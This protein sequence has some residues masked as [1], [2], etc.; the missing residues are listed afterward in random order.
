MAREIKSVKD[1]LEALDDS[2]A[3]ISGPRAKLIVDVRDFFAK[4]HANDPAPEPPAAEPVAD[5]PAVTEPPA[6]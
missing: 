5:P 1:A 6:S 2:A 3:S 4:L